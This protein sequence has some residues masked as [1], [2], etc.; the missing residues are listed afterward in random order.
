MAVLLRHILTL[1]NRLVSTLQAVSSFTHFSQILLLALITNLPGLFLTVLS[2]AVLL[3]LLWSSLHFE[4]TDFLWLEMTILLF[5]G[6]WE[7]VR[8][9]L[10]VPMNIGFAHFNLDL[11]W[12]VVAILS[13]FP[14]AYYSL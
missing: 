13:W 11:T 6:K 3:C 14:I 1:L 9:F 8:E 10:T 2:V 7:D 4:L 5:H 12:N